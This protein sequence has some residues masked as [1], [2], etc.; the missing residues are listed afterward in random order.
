MTQAPDDDEVTAFLLAARNAKPVRLPNGQ[1]ILIGDD[2]YRVTGPAGM[3]AQVTALIQ[4]ALRSMVL[5]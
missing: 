1:G 4:L 3:D 2:V 5:G